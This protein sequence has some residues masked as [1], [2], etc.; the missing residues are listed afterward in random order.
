MVILHNDGT[1]QVVAGIAEIGVGAET[2][3]AQIAA[4]ELGLPVAHVSVR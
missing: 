2:V 1:A 4:E 3:L